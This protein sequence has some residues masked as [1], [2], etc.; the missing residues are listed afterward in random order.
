ML[1]ITFCCLTH[2]ALTPLWELANSNMPSALISP[3]ASN[4]LCLGSHLW[5][6]HHL[7]YKTA[8]RVRLSGFGAVTGEIF[9][10]CKGPTKP[11]N[12]RLLV[13][14]LKWAQP[15][16]LLGP[17]DWS[18]V[19]VQGPRGAFLMTCGY[20]K[21]SLGCNELVSSPVRKALGHYHP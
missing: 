12:S 19:A 21:G 10:D 5:L 9:L 14:A 13:P 15:G 16:P 17:Q 2:P 3:R 7:N 8:P 20:L 18:L 4:D 11:Q 1:F 6:K